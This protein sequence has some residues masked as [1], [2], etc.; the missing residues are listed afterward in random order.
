MLVAYVAAL[1]VAFG[2]LAVQLLASGDGHDAGG[3]DVGAHEGGDHGDSG[4]LVGVFLSVRFWTFA[5][6][7]FGLSG[8]LLH[9]FQLASAWATAMLA[10]GTGAAS[11]LFA[12]LV[13]RAL[14]RSTS[15]AVQR[16]SNAI[17]KGGRVLIACSKGRVG[18]VRVEL[19]GSSLDLM[20]TTDEDEIPRGGQVL[21]ENVTGGVAHVSKQPLELL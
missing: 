2:I 14:T 1:V 9:A 16:A 3:D 15:P 13:F 11:G 19:D 5:L 8:T 10:G 21:I 7:G 4:A 20:A 6:L 12:A 17:G 18:Q